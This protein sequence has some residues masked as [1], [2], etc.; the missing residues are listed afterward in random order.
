MQILGRPSNCFTV[1]GKRSTHDKCHAKIDL[2][3]IKK[4][5]N[6]LVFK[7]CLR[8]GQGFRYQNRFIRS[9]PA[10]TGT[11]I[12]ILFADAFPLFDVPDSI[13]TMIEYVQ[14]YLN[15]EQVGFPT[16]YITYNL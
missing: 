7:I 9:A 3:E 8:G 14:P 10:V 15:P 11:R 5:G 12:L 4:I 6:F 13:F 1:T 2:F 16:V